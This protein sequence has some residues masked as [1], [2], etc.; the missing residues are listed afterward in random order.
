MSRRQGYVIVPASGIDLNP[1]E[2]D[3]IVERLEDSAPL[4][5]VEVHIAD[6]PVRERQAQPVFADD[7]DAM[8]PTPR[9]GR[10]RGGAA[11]RQ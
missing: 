9:R 4:A 8:R 11:R 6:G 7:L 10:E 2:L 5:T 1:R 3:G